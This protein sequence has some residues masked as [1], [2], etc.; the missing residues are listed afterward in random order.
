MGR[1]KAQV[2]KEICLGSGVCARYLS[3]RSILV[4]IKKRIITPVNS[5]YRIGMTAIE[6]GQLHNLILDNK[7]YSCLKAMAAILSVI[8]KYICYILGFIEGLNIKM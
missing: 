3:S 8:F 5:V 4:E 6:R 1:K 2:N 7:A